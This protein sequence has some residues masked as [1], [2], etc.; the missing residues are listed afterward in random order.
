MKLYL[1]QILTL[2]LIVFSIPRTFSQDDCT[3]KL[4]SAQK[5][6]DEGKIEKVPD[7]IDNCIESGFNKENRVAALK[8]LSLVYLYEDNMEK[9][10]ETLLKLL[11]I[12]P[13][14]VIDRN[15]DPIEFIRLHAMY[16]T[17][18][19]FS[20]GALLGANITNI[21]PIITNSTYDFAKA[22]VSYNREGLGIV[23]GAKLTYHYNDDI[24]IVMEPKYSTQKYSLNER[25]S[26]YSNFT[27]IGSESFIEIPALASYY[28]YNYRD[29]SFFGELGFSY[30]I[31]LNSEINTPVNSS[32]NQENPRIELT[33]INSK[34]FRSNYLATGIIGG[35]V[36]YKMKR[37]N[38]QLSI[39]YNLGFNNI[40]PEIDI[41]SMQ[42]NTPLNNMFWDTQYQENK[43]SIS[44]LSFVISYNREFYIHSKKK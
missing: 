44:S 5:L 37:D 39:R 3:V 29:F 35:G 4:K 21:R 42:N 22:N 11:K 23:L 12:E 33:T 40:A 9:A 15:L 16:N 26:T 6:F 36:K 24:D 43:F 31:L 19:V 30:G 38:I 13:E 32:D 28:F 20:I 18:S 1:A 2:F 41:N 14:Y 10:E 17:E 25:L 34:S 7:L 8:L 27:G